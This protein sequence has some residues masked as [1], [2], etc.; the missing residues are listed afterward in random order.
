MPRLR[1]VSTGAV[2]NVSDEKAAVL[3]AEWQPI[4]EQATKPARRKS[5]K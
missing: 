5:A 3:G 1:N 2:V 4:D